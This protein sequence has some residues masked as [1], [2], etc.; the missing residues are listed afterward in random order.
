MVCPTIQRHLLGEDAPKDAEGRRKIINKLQ[1]ENA[2]LKEELNVAQT[3]FK[4]CMARSAAYGILQDKFYALK[5][6]VEHEKGVLTRMNRDLKCLQTGVASGAE[7][8]NKLRQQL[9]EL[10]AK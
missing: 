4:C 7:K 9:A 2:G 1:K 10:T 3:S 8:V 5:A 6:E